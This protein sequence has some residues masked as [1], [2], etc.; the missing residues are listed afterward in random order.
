ML[1]VAVTS[2]I[3]Y[4]VLAYC[5]ANYE[6]HLKS[7]NTIKTSLLNAVTQFIYNKIRKNRLWIKIIIIIIVQIKKNSVVVLQKKIHITKTA[8]KAN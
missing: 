1:Y 6:I 7:K 3:F 2:P 8:C 5:V 4:T